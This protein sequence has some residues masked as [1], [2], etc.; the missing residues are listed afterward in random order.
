MTTNGQN[1]NSSNAI[2]LLMHMH[3]E[4]KQ[5][6]AQ[7]LG[8]SD[9]Q[10]AALMWRQLQPILKVHEQMEEQYLYD[11]LKA[12]QGG[13]T[14]LGAWEPQHEREVNEVEQMIAQ[15]QQM[16]QG[17][18]GWRD[19]IRLISDT[20]A[21][22]IAEEEGTIFPRIRQVWDEQKLQQAGMQMQQMKQ[23]KLSGVAS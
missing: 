19:Q 4:A 23:Q 13:N 10:R 1:V 7:I 21:E 14:E 11:P 6:F 16:E 20:L 2:D 12:E 15:A 5:Q 22:H 18:A 17:A 3:R 9:G 8:E